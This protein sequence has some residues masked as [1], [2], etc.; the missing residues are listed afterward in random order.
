MQYVFL[1]R[2][3]SNGRYA[4]SLEKLAMGELS[5]FLNAMDIH[6]TLEL[7]TLGG[8]RFLTF[9]SSEPLTSCQ[10]KAL[11]KHS[12]QCFM[13]QRQPDGAL[14]P[15]DSNN[16]LFLPSDLSQ[17]MKYKGKTN[18]EFT[19]MMI[20]CALCASGQLLNEQR[21]TLLD[22]IM[23]KG[24]TLMCA[25][26]A[27]MNA[28]GVELDE[29]AVVET[30]QYLERYLKFHH[31]KHRRE[32]ASLTIPAGK[33]AKSVTYTLSDTPEHYKQGDT[34]TLQ[35]ICA[36]TR[37]TDRL[38]GKAKCDL[39]IGDLPYGIQHAPKQ[40]KNMS[41]LETLLSQSLPA[42]VSAL[43]PHGAIALSFNT[44]TLKREVVVELMDRAG[45]HPLIDPPYHDFEH[46]VEQAVMRDFVVAVR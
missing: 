34:R 27:G 9:D 23:G 38:V 3:H 17:V 39:I 10:I 21:I 8:G 40:G 19:R 42:Y 30:D 14:Y 29:K 37:F 26:E 24:T 44:Y 18:V 33:N 41:E 7:R 28:I 1:V 43:K 15:L 13:A 16:V 35:L 31:M 32:A 12:A 25:L 2:P 45:L 20:N 22:P 36:D 6:T 5:C 11:S 46:W 4:A